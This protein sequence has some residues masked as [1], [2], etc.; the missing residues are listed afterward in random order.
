MTEAG[1]VQLNQE[2]IPSPVI[3]SVEPTDYRFESV[4]GATQFYLQ[5][6]EIDGRVTEHGPFEL[7]GEYGSAAGTN[8]VGMTQRVWLPMVAGE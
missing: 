5:E 3:D 7:G 6:L 8:D 4:T 2:L 1:K